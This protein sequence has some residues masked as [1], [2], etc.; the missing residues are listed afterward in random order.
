MLLLPRRHPDV[1]VLENAVQV[2]AGRVPL[3]RPRRHQRGARFARPR[4]RSNKR[5]RCSR[6]PAGSRRRL[7]TL[8][9]TGAESDTGMF[10]GNSNWRGPVW[11]PVNLILLRALVNITPTKATRD[12]SLTR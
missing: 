1:F 5:W 12:L 9:R 8:A 11:M 3:R 7:C 10:G 6:T 2:P 4:V